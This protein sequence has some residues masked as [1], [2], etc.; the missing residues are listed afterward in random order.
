MTFVAIHLISIGTYKYHYTKEPDL[1]HG[2][3][4][5]RGPQKSGPRWSGPVPPMSGS[6]SA[7][8]VAVH[9]CAV[10]GAKK[11]D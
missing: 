2:L 10:L 11:P 4:W 3:F 7:G 6:R 5:L 8:P 9:G 1:E